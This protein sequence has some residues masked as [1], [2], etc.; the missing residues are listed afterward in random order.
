MGSERYTIEGGLDGYKDELLER[1]RAG[2]VPAW[3]YPETPLS[4]TDERLQR[5]ANPDEFLEACIESARG[6]STDPFVPDDYAIF[7]LY[8]EA[9]NPLTG[10]GGTGT[11]EDPVLAPETLRRRIIDWLDANEERIMEEDEYADFRQGPRI[12]VTLGDDGTIKDARLEIE[13][14]N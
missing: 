5:D 1:L 9:D 3:M 2:E 13:Y 10:Q 7:A 11:R 6:G 14:G 4:S 8:H 12:Y